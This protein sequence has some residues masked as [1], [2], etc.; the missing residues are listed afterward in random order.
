MVTADSKDTEIDTGKN[1]NIIGY[2]NLTLM[3]GQFFKGLFD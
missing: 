1:I 2:R 3:N